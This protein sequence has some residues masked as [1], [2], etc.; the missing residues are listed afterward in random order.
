MP[1]YFQ[2]L[3]ISPNPEEKPLL[4]LNPMLMF[5]QGSA[6]APNPSRPLVMRS[7]NPIEEPIVPQFPLFFQ[8]LPIS[9]NP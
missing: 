9:P 1:L 8:G 3:P 4:T 2:G 7:N 6:I 5:F